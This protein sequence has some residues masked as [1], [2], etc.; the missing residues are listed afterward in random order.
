MTAILTSGVV[1]GAGTSDLVLGSLASVV[2]E[3]LR[4]GLGGQ[5]GLTLAIP[6][7][8]L[9]TGP[10][11]ERHLT[12]RPSHQTDVRET[13]QAGI[14]TAG[15]QDV[16]SGPGHPTAI[17]G[18]GAAGGGGDGGP[19]KKV[20]P[21]TRTRALSYSPRDQIRL[22]EELAVERATGKPNQKAEAVQWFEIV[23]AGV[24]TQD[25][26]FLGLAI[27]QAI[28]GKVQ[29]G[30]TLTKA[31]PRHAVWEGSGGAALKG[32]YEGDGE[33]L[34]K[35]AEYYEHSGDNQYPS[36][37]AIDV[38]GTE[39][40]VGLP[41][42]GDLFPE[43]VYGNKY[44]AL[45]GS[46]LAF[47]LKILTAGDW[48]ANLQRTCV[49][50][51]QVNRLPQAAA[52]REAL[53]LSDLAHITDTSQR[54]YLD[55]YLRLTQ[56]IKLM[57]DAGLE[58]E[59]DPLV[60]ELMGM[61]NK[62][63]SVQLHPSRKAAALDPRLGS[64]TEGW[65]VISAPEG[66]GFVL[67]LKEGVDFADVERALRT[68]ESLLPFLHFVPVKEGEALQIKDDLH[69]IVGVTVWEPQSPDDKTLI[70]TARAYDWGK[71][72]E[73]EIHAER[74]LE[75]LKPKEDAGQ[76]LRGEEGVDQLRRQ[77]VVIYKGGGGQARV[78]GLV[79]DKVIFNK[80]EFENE[81][82]V[83]EVDTE[84]TGIQGFTVAKGS[85]TVYNQGD[86]VIGVVEQ[87]YSFMVFGDQTARVEANESGTVVKQIYATTD[88]SLV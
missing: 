51:D 78:M 72:P 65:V 33:T 74:V 67:G 61:G 5:P 9:W 31:W 44:L 24:E 84:E 75:L 55:V 79:N 8:A 41:I 17:R 66:S 45:H 43:S 23:R 86:E 59:A 36:K 25:A 3:G 68:G 83:F 14:R 71:I 26:E 88:K 69:A 49:L 76:L 64:K 4:F 39:V 6:D 19:P 50:L 20:T 70:T 22:I 63:L 56:L 52:W 77:P 81:K 62:C 27:V 42:I 2:Q 58:A 16:S 48:S 21:M 10:A 57:I 34:K 53:G 82:D 30:S 28:R 1:G 29:K 35:V 60:R 87:G 15:Q 80:I 46:K 37:M 40:Q 11:A 13:S 18:S 73:R 38:A 12:A 47:M 32:D 85:V 54:H 7:Q